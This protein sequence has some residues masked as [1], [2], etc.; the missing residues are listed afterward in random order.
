MKISKNR[1][2]QA[3][4]TGAG[5]R[6]GRARQQYGETVKRGYL[7]HPVGGGRLQRVVLAGRL[8]V[9]VLGFQLAVAVAAVAQALAVPFLLLGLAVAADPKPLSSAPAMA[10]VRQRD[11]L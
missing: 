6:R 8:V 2:G 11:R 7:G 9:A 3:L 1:A 10:P 5:G 4:V